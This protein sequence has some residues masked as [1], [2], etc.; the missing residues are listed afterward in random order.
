[1][2]NHEV[3]VNTIAATTTLTGLRVHAAL[4]ESSY[5]TGI[6][7][8]DARMAAL[9]IARHSF[10]GDWNYTLHRQASRAPQDS[11]DQA[12]VPAPDRWDRDSLTHPTMTGMSP[13]DLT[14]LT[15]SL[16]GLRQAR[17]QEKQREH[18]QGLRRHAPRSGRPL[19][20][21]FPDRVL[22]TILHLRL[23]LPEDT[24]AVLLH[25]SRSTIRRA[26]R[27]TRQLLDEQH[28]T[29]QPAPAPS[30]AVATLLAAGG[31]AA[32]TTKIKAAS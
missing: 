17:W 6:R 11:V 31:Q 19:L 30:A 14:A 2:T 22:A 18:H 4:D 13:Q 21:A 10:H 20:L 5:P 16:N 8:S 27:E 3:V 25:T 28:T 32:S 26:L 12:Q 23:H 9:P 15:A 1:M 7:I 29:I 24:L